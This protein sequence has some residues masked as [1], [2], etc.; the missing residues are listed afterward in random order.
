MPSL[1]TSLFGMALIAASPTTELKYDGT[2]SRLD[3]SGDSI[4]V[5]QFDLRCYVT[6]D[7][8][9]RSS[10]VFLTT[11]DGGDAIAWPE[12]IGRVNCQF[13]PPQQ[14]GDAIQVLYNH[15]DRPHLLSLPCP[16]F[17]HRAQLAADAAWDTDAVR[18]TVAGSQDVDGRTC[19]EVEA[20]STGRGG[21][22][23]F[24]VDPE[25]GII[26]SGSRRLS[27][28][29]GVSFELAW[30]LDTTRELPPE[31]AERTAAAA[32]NLLTLRSSL[33]R[34][35]AGDDPALSPSQLQTA[36]AALG[37]LQQHAA[38][39]S[40]A[41]LATVI[42]R[43]V[44]AQQQR[45]ESVS[46]L[47]AKFVGQPAPD[48]ALVGLDGKAISD[49]ARQ[50]KTLVL[51]FWEYQ[52]EPLEEPYG[53]IGYLDFLM[54]RHPAEKLQVYG[55]AVDR[56]L[57]DPA[58][59]PQAARS[60]KRLKAFMNLGYD[61]AADRDGKLLK[62]FGDPTQFDAELPLWVVIAPDGKIVHYRTG[63]YDVDRE[64]G[65]AEIDAIVSELGRP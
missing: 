11:E 59:A 61:I 2:L 28:G 12:R 40:F 14:G 48:F 60:A 53:Q 16:V 51:H 1:M 26:Q 56:Q 55:V 57:R 21:T 58:T 27:M 37:D 35:N 38:E 65:L 50:G 24:V 13:D 22:S 36:A 15:D 23:R 29:Q 52:D 33:E 19:W 9:G 3:R 18:Y 44:Q 7:D 45:A 62:A 54:N 49:E 6:G 47:S 25:T 46:E 4:Q 64:V 5:K 32:E 43:D 42:A 34:E 10:I 39:T 17:E 20:A 63:F 31:E 30:R 8:N 41:R